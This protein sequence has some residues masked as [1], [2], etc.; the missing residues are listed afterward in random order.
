MPTMRHSNVP[1]HVEAANGKRLT[2]QERIEYL[3]AAAAPT[4]AI[5]AQLVILEDFILGFINGSSFSGS[6][7]CQAAMSQVVFYGFQVVSYREVYIPKNIMK[8]AIAVQ[9]LNQATVIFTA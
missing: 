9:N 1:D 5:S 4:D 2:T 7:K 8:A 6:V 3:T